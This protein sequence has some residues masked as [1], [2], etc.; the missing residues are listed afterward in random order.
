MAVRKTAPP[1]ELVYGL[2]EDADSLAFIEREVLELWTSVIDE[3][4]S[5]RTVGDARRALQEFAA[6]ASWLPVDEDELE[7]EPDDAPFTVEDAG[8]VGDG[9]W[10]TTAQS[11]SLSALPDEVIE[12]YADTLLTTFSGDL[13]VIDPAHE[14]AIVADLRARGIAVVR[15]DKAIGVL[16]R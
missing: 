16:R 7:D 8:A 13:A 10:P 11:L 4:D 2:V 5:W 15:D 14:A 3:C 9:D 1:T 6:L 12:K